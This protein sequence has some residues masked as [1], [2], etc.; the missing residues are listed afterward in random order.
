MRRGTRAGSTSGRTRRVGSAAVLRDGT[1][2]EKALALSGAVLVLV[3]T[4]LTVLEPAALPLMSGALFVHLTALLLL[5]RRV[6]R[7]RQRDRLL[8][9]EAERGLRELERWL[10]GPRA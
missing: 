7:R 4:A 1:G 3:L 10:S 8:A 6:Q 9:A 2:L 5:Q